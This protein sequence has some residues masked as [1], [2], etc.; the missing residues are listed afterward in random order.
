MEA[1]IQ[2]CKD[3]VQPEYA[4]VHIAY[5]NGT[6]VFQQSLKV[7]Q[8]SYPMQTYVSNISQQTYQIGWQ[9][10]YTAFSEYNLTLVPLPEDSEHC[11]QVKSKQN[12]FW[13]GQAEVLNL[14]NNDS[15]VIGDGFVEVFNFSTSFN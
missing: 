9:L 6:F 3:P 14:A 4:R 10:D 12:C 5:T 13:L 8:S 1:N 15:L 11:F 7:F 2:T